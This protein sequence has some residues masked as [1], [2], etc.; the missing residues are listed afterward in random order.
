M[1]DQY[2]WWWKVSHEKPCTH[3]AIYDNNEFIGQ[4]EISNIIPEYG[5]GEIG[6]II[7]PKKRGKGRGREAVYNILRIGFLELNLY[8]I[9]G[10]VYHCNAARTFWESIYKDMGGTMTILPC[11]KH[12][13]SQYYDSTYFSISRDQFVRF[14]RG[15][16]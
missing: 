9:F 10:E 5:I 15:M 1:L 14:A 12:W 11:R 13:R 2:K 16:V 8:T 4:G 3:W 7:D 6:L